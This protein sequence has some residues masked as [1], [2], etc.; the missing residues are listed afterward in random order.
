MAKKAGFLQDHPGFEKGEIL[1]SFDEH[2]SSGKVRRVEKVFIKNP[3]KERVLALLWK[4]Y[5]S[6]F[7]GNVRI[8]TDLSDPMI[9]TTEELRRLDGNWVNEIF[10]VK[11][12]RDK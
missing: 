4:I 3:T 9:I 11:P 1:F 6:G 8:P 2:G 12:G 10:Q 5:S 7:K